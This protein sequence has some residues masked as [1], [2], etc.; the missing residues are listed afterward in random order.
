MGTAFTIETPAPNSWVHTLRGT[1]LPTVSTMTLNGVSSWISFP[2]SNSWQADVVLTPGDN[3]FT[4]QATDE[5]SNKTESKEITITL[6]SYTPVV[7]EVFND[8]ASHAMFQGLR[9]IPG[10]KNIYLHRRL[11]DAP[12][13]PTGTDYDGMI[14]A[15]S[16]DLGLTVHRQALSVT[17]NKDTYKNLLSS[18]AT[19]EITASHI[20]VDADE[21]FAEDETHIVD[22][23]Y[24]GF[25]LTYEPRHE[26]DIEIYTRDNTL[27]DPDEYEVVCYT[28]LVKFKNETYN[29]QWVRARYN[30]RV[31]VDKTGTLATIKSALEAITVN[32]SQLMTIEVDDATR[33]ADGLNHRARL[34][35]SSTTEY[36]KWSYVQIY[37]LHDERFRDSLLNSNGAAYSTVLEAWAKNIA[38]RSKFSWKALV[39]D[40]DNWDPLY[41]RRNNARLPHLI[42]PYRGYWKC[43]DPTDSTRY[44]S[45][46]NAAYAGQCPI[47]PGKSL[48]YVGVKPE[49]WHSG[50]GN[51]NDMEVL[52]IERVTE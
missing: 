29:R 52:L 35:I 1:R 2:T 42:D 17:L 19:M 27:V 36:I 26:E 33:T 51:N 48:T 8:T 46:D 44:T 43:D 3:V 37:N 4:I 5:A 22:P 45:S 50:I 18:T 28:R 11:S 47:H 14:E 24:P 13:Y 32:G 30:Y 12:Y 21:I 20:L 23:A 9:R 16:R 25:Y 15:I 31:S 7:R 38:K 10:E 49:Q 40:V 39:L 41:W 34:T 6:K